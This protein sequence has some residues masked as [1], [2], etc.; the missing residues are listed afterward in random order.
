MLMMLFLGIAFSNLQQCWACLL[1]FF[2]IEILFFVLF[3]VL[4]QIYIFCPKKKKRKKNKDILQAVIFCC[5]F[6]LFWIQLG[7]LN[8]IQAMELAPEL[9]YPLYIA[10]SVDWYAIAFVLNYFF[11]FLIESSYWFVSSGW[12]VCGLSCLVD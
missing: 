10:A 11:A 9:V 4:N 2:L 5:F 8:V 3:A 7:I 12:F 1:H 6:F